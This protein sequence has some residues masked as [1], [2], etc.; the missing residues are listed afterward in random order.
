MRF[1]YKTRLEMEHISFLQA[2]SAETGRPQTDLVNEAIVLYRESLDDRAAFTP[3]EPPKE[4]REAPPEPQAG[5][6]GLV[7][8]LSLGGIGTDVPRN[9]ESPTDVLAREIADAKRQRDTVPTRLREFSAAD[10]RVEHDKWDGVVR[11]LE[12]ERL[13]H[14][15]DD[16]YEDGSKGE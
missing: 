16:M 1:D 12:A 6:T 14:D 9:I 3:P 15:I 11:R 13:N 8:P 7:D 4:A 10:R 2:R 5:S